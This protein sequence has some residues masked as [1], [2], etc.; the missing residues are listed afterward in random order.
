MS[1]LDRRMRFGCGN[2]LMPYVLRYCQRQ[3]GNFERALSCTGASGDYVCNASN[4][5]AD[6]ENTLSVIGVLCCPG[7]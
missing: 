3:C 1:G 2:L 7:P 6:E 4:S 5:L